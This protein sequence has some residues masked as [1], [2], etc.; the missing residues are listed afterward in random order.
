[1]NLTAPIINRVRTYLRKNKLDALVVPSADPHQSEYTQEHD[2]C[3]AYVSGFYGSAGTV[4]VTQSEAGLW[5]DSRYFLAAET[6]IAGSE[7]CLFRLHEEGVLDYPA[8]LAAT[9]PAGSTVGVDGG[10]VTLAERRTLES[11][12]GLRNIALTA[13]I[14]P[15][16]EL[17]PDRPPLVS[18]PVYVLD[19][20]YAGV[21]TREKIAN[22]RAA[23]AEAS[24]TTHIVST[25]DDIAWILNLRGSDVAYNPV[26]RAYLVV[27][28]DRVVLYR[29]RGTISED[30]RVALAD[31]EIAPYERFF[32]DLPTLTGPV[33]IDPQ[34][35]SWSI[36]ESLSEIETVEQMQPSTVAKACKNSTEL[37]NLEHAMARDGAALVRF[38]AWLDGIDPVREQ[39]NENDLA[40]TL[41]RFRQEDALSIGDSFNYIS[42]FGP[43][44][45]IIHYD[46]TENGPSTIDAPGIY[47]I[48]SGGQYLDGT[49]DVT[50][51]LPIGDVSQIE[52]LLRRAATDHTLVLKGHIA[53]A[54]LRF[55]FG[56]S[57]RDI[58]AIARA[59][60]WA[61]ARSYSHGTGH[62]VGFV[63]NVHEGPQ[64]IAPGADPYPLQPGM[65][66]S[67]EPGIYRTGEYG[68]RFENLVVVE[69]VEKSEFGT[70]LG[71][72]TLTLAP[73]D[74][75]LIVLEL[76]QPEDIDWID[77]YHE[78][79]VA[80]LSPL[81]DDEELRWLERM[82]RPLTAVE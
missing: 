57:G 58:D 33:L 22:L 51:T 47:L 46:P 76:L 75:R 6:A 18:D 61:A 68:I 13:L 63:L 45:A 65:L 50:R 52:D 11:Q 72:R 23:I 66:V 69:E 29:D 64:R 32:V 59:P 2:R 25:L 28:L 17:W 3:R 40:D 70:F 54:Q 9:L 26:F 8:W 37:S 34:R 1:M 43:N 41:R 10:V 5:T 55:P 31:V 82:C 7:F 74:R 39:L 36:A 12:L 15:F 42:G 38:F 73:I 4:V 81:L 49:T 35:T 21:S 60:L 24:A 71:F 67:N 62:G 14:D 19:D 78:Q 80:A 56:T 77:R 20:T 30:V 48:D 27:S 16:A 53:L 44:G 79:V